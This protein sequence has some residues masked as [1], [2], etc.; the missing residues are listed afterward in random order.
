[1]AS[2]G[3]IQGLRLV[4]PRKE[5]LLQAGVENVEKNIINETYMSEVNV[6]Q[7]YKAL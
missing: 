7:Q 4:T 1:V 2:K 5:R 3:K 6:Q